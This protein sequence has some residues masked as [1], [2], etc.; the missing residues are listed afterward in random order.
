MS[1][2][3]DDEVKKWRS[4]CCRRGYA[5]AEIEAV[6]SKY[7]INGDR[8]LDDAELRQMTSDLEGQK[9]KSSLLAGSYETR[10]YNWIISQ[11]IDVIL[12][13]CVKKTD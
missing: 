5:E 4:D 11:S 12:L 10:A 6:F 1:Q 9:V 8:A 13:T 2:I 3:A 7:D